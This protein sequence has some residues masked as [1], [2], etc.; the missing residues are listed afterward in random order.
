MKRPKNFLNIKDRERILL[1]IQ[2]EEVSHFMK[3]KG[4]NTRAA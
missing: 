4:K 2:P 1:S 3:E